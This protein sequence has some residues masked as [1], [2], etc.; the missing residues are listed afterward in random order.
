L[1]YDSGYHPRQQGLAR[2]LVDAGADVVVGHHPHVLEPVEVYKQGVI[3]YSLGNFVFDQ[4]WSRTRE[5]VLV[6]YKLLQGGKKAKLEL[7][8]M[9]IR[10]GQPRPLTGWSNVYRREKIFN[11]LTEEFMYSDKWNQ[12]WTRE[13]DYISRIIPLSGKGRPPAGK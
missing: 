2:A 1:E 3:L 10:E 5:S 7:H 12:T 6:Q 13:G 4:G 11:Q 9:V 8:P